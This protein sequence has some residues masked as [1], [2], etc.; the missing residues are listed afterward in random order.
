MTVA[1]C[2]ACTT[3]CRLFRFLCITKWTPYRCPDCGTTSRYRNVEL[4]TSLAAPTVAGVTVATVY[5]VDTSFGTQSFFFAPLVAVP[6]L[7]AV[8]Y[9]FTRLAPCNDPRER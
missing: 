5:F 1:H 7:F 2:P 4:V 9:R 8:M 3:R 6:L